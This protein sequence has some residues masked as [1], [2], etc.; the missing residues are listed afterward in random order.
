MTSDMQIINPLLH[1]VWD[2]WVL[3]AVNGSFFHTQAWAEVL[4]ATY[5]YKPVYFTILRND[6]I[7][8]LIPILEIKSR[9]TG[10]RGVSL[11]F[12]DY[13]EPIAGSKTDFDQM[14]GVITDYARNSNWK[15]VEIRGAAFYLKE[16]P[17]YDAYYLYHLKLNRSEKEILKDFRSS[18]RRNI[19]F[20]V[21]QKV[22]IE[23]ANSLQAVRYFYHLMCLTR[24]RHGLPPQPFS[25]FYNIYRFILAEDKGFIVLA[26][27]NK[28]LIA[29]ALYLK[30][31]KKGIYKFG[32]SDMKFQDLRANN[33]VMWSAIQWFLK[34]G[35]EEFD[36]GRTEIDNHGLNQ[37][38]IRMGCGKTVVEIFQI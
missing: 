32:A 31:S 23:F 37:F 11:P 5:R 8:S 20:A 14:L 6:E 17:A 22:R 34:N 21:K 33:L 12:T 9:L 3:K 29:G 1:R 7:Y 18:T 30:F 25:F 36:F 4:H 35:F 19:K 13:C 10:K 38:E 24:K 15:H 28:H 2:Q 26:S 27:S 16:F